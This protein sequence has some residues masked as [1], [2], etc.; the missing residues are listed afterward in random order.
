MILLT[1]GSGFVGRA[2]QA[3]LK[4]QG[5][6]FRVSLRKVQDVDLADTTN[7]IQCA[8]SPDADWS[9]ALSGVTTV[10]HCAARVHVMKEDASV[11]PLTEFRRIN[12]EGTLRLA[13]QA[14]QA[15]VKRFV[16]VSSIKVNGELTPKDLPFTPEQAPSPADPYGMSKWEAEEALMA[17]SAE[18]GM[19]VV[20]V[21]PPLVYGPGVKANFALLMN[22]V[23]RGWILPLG[24][25]DNKRSLIGIDNLIDFL[26][27]CIDHPN[28]ANQIFLVSDG[29]DLSTSELVRCMGRV[30]G[31][32]AR[33][34]TIPVWMLQIGATL[35]GKK[36]MFQRLCG[37]L[38]VDI[39][40]ARTMLAWTPSI[41]VSEGLKRAMAH[42]AD[43]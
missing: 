35:L 18:T 9:A 15:G 17:L 14:A 33:L 41:S 29:Q 11:D 36:D 31:L 13:R 34:V 22:A 10:V 39:S 23:R 4:K 5:R 12:V 43:F 19:E 37:N 24:A 25:I 42:E 28:A 38:Q 2:L 40:K 20:M 16:F 32:R 26:I 3:A 1:G 27:R 21:R 6:S 7:V 30:A 8:L